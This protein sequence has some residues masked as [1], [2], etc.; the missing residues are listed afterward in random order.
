MTTA[1][2]SSTAGTD[3]TNVL[4]DGVLRNFLF[5]QTTPPSLSANTLDLTYTFG[6][7]AV[8]FHSTAGLGFD[9]VLGPMIGIVNGVDTADSHFTNT[10]FAL[11]DFTVAVRDGDL[12][13]LNKLLWNG[14]DTI[15]GAASDD[16]VHGFAGNDVISGGDGNDKL[17]GDLGAD[18]LRGGNG[19]DLLA[20]G[21]GADQLFGDAGN[22]SLAGGAGNDR[23]TGG[24]GLDLVYGGA[25]ADKFIFTKL[26]D[27][28]PYTATAKISYDAILDFNHTAG[29][30]IDLHLIDADSTLSGN[31]A[32]MFIGSAD[33][34]ANSPGT[35]HI[36][37]TG[38]S[39]S[40][41]VQLNTDNDAQP[42]ATFLVVCRPTVVLP[43]GLAPI[44]DDFI[45]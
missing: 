24:T 8:V 29:D 23:I 3:W 18:Q 10:N 45:L 14:N 21:A 12:D 27:F 35:L 11:A 28:A 39:H 15:T 40:F 37:A 38:D 6:E 22:D 9:P 41:L 2:T 34:A 25:G 16:L 17:F 13:A 32:F 30:K 19:D 42:E 20:G 4:G 7:G 5:G 31:Q 33:F 26:A 36:K 44:A 43:S 1:S